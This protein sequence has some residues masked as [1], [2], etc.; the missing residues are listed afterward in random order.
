MVIYVCYFKLNN[1][2]QEKI[3]H[4]PILNNFDNILMV[5]AFLI[6]FEY[7]LSLPTIFFMILVLFLTENDL[8]NKYC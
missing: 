1:L 4:R 8:N 2:Q 6:T 7:L 5:L 3:I